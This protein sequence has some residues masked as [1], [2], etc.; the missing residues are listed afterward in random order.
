MAC[1]GRFYVLGPPTQHRD[2]LIDLVKSVMRQTAGLGLAPF[3]L[4]YLEGPVRY[5]S[6]WI[7]GG[8]NNVLRQ[9]LEV[10]DLWTGEVV[11]NN[12]GLARSFSV[13]VIDQEYVEGRRGDRRSLPV[14]ETFVVSVL[15]DDKRGVSRVYEWRTRPQETWRYRGSWL[16]PLGDD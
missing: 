13:V 16:K 14:F 1:L 11:W 7:P 9:G 6:S 10:V 3:T 4:R 2:D 15:Q 12:L 5:D 8:R